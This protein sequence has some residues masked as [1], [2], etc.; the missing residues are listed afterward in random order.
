MVGHTTLREIVGTD[1]L[2][3][4]SGA[5]LASS[6]L[7]LSVMRLLHFQIVQLCTQHLQRLVLILQLGLLVLTRDDNSGRNMGQTYCR[8]CRI[9]ALSTVSGCTEHIE[10][11]VVHVN[12]HVHVLCLR[13]DRYRNCR[14][15][16]PSAG[17]SLRYT[18]YA[19]YT[20]L[21]LQFGVR[22]LSGDHEADI[23][24]ATDTDLLDI[25]C[26][27]TPALTLSIVYIHPIYLGRKQCRLISACAR[28]DL[29]DNVLVII[30]I[31]RQQ[32][33]FQLL[34]KLLNAATCICKLF[35]EHITH[36]FIGLLLQ[37]GETLF[38]RLPAVLILLIGIYDRLKAALLLHQLLK[39][40]RIPDH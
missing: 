16:D 34:L 36:L 33:N 31:L 2:G 23:L 26:L 13:H 3:A 38:D 22:A 24:H 28:T 17:L 4:V 35:L 18:L 10:F 25:H 29:D 7:S 5:D 19:M 11:T 9:D 12:L 15:M 40:L 30:R 37:H 27:D 1:L 20:G 39:P 32:K 21:I 6:R 14:C 8:V